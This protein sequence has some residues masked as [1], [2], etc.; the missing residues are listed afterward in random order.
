[1]T[2]EKKPKTKPEPKIDNSMLLNFKMLQAQK[3]I[4]AS[5]TKVSNYQAFEYTTICYQNF[6]GYRQT[7]S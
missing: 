1:M 6:R 5:R 7:K 4:E 3:E 2:T